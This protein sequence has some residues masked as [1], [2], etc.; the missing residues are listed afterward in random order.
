MVNTERTADVLLLT[1]GTTIG[2]AN[3]ESVL[4]IVILALQVIW[5]GAKIISKI[6]TALKT[7]QPLKD[8]EINVSATLCKYCPFKEQN[9]EQEVS[10][11][12]QHYEQE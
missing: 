2:F 6:Y 9:Q 3:I 5:F 8:E 4:G 1:A 12:E 7:K 11:N 10:E